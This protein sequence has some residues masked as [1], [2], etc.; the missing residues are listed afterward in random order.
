MTISLLV[1]FLVLSFVLLRGEDRSV[2][3][4]LVFA[5]TGFL[6][7]S[8]SAGPVINDALGKLAQAVTQIG[9]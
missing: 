9:S 3:R 8:T 2:G 1:L 4:A 7:A 6:L 5:L